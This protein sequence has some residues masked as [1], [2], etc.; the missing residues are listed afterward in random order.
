[1]NKHFRFPYFIWACFVSVSAT[2][3]SFLAAERQK[4]FILKSN[5]HKE[6]GNQ[7]AKIRICIFRNIMY[8]YFLLSVGALLMSWSLREAASPSVL[9]DSPALTAW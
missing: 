7:T 3:I 5:E 2:L 9:L 6:T 1:M 4:N 8:I